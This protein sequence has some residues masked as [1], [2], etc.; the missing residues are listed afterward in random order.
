MKEKIRC[1][2]CK[3]YDNY[4]MLCRFYEPQDKNHRDNTCKY[5]EAKEI[6]IKNK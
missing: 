1:K 3:Y 6:N 4:T 2:D 5:A